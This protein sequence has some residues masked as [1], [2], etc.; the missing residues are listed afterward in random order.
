MIDLHCHLLPGID[1]GPR[2]VEQSLALARAALADGTTTMVATPH[3]SFTYPNDATVI[4]GRVTEMRERLAAE[5]LALEVLPG[6]EISLARLADLEP[7]ELRRLGLGGGRWLLI[8]PPFSTTAGRLDA[9]LLALARRGNRIVLAHP[10]RCPA[11][12]RDPSA[13]RALIDAGVLTSVTAGSF[14]GRFGEPARR[15]ALELAGEEMLHNVASDAHDLARRPPA[16]ADCLHRAG[17]ES[18]RE[19]LTEAVPAA[20]LA[21]EPLP[22][23]PAAAV[24]MRSRRRWRLG[25]G[26]LRRAW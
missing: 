25:G 9:I 12:H 11:F 22:E 15:F 2:T 10:E 7:L 23:R 6:A 4:S 24:A 1:D 26:R 8:E 20:I 3:V 17:L 14:V 5:R 19:W 21:D 18:L 16:I 13:L